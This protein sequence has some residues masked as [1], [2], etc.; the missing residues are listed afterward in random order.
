MERYVLNWLEPLLKLTRTEYFAGHCITTPLTFAMVGLSLY[1]GL[2]GS[3][4]DATMNWLP[5]FAAGVF[6]WTAYE[7][8]LHRWML[9][10]WPLMKP[11]HD[12]HHED[13]K[14][15]IGVHPIALTFLYALLWA[16]V[17][18]HS[19]AV[20]AGFS[21]GYLIYLWMHTAFHYFTIKKDS[22]LFDM[23][24]HHALHHKFDY[25]NFGV[26]TKLWDHL[27]GTY[28]A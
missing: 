21:V 10:H 13:Q 9:H 3:I 15:Y 19:T 26:T 24:R 23:K 4:A 11:M 6:A 12:W 2:D 20:S 17:G 7:Y 22:W 1:A 28:I 14:A 25:V 5:L 16:T 27:F 8:L 18:E